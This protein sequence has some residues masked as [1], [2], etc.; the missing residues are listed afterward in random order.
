MVSLNINLDDLDSISA[1]DSSYCHQSINNLTDQLEFSWSD[2]QRLD[3]SKISTDISAVYFCGMGG[4]AY[5][6]RITKFLFR[7]RLKIPFEIVDNYN[8]P[9]SVDNRSLIFCA[10]YSGHTEETLSCLNQAI[11]RNL[12]LIGVTTGG[13]LAKILKQSN[14]P[15]YQ[16]STKLNPSNQPRL[17]QGYMIASSL[18]LLNK[19]KFIDIESSELIEI[20]SELKKRNLTLRWDSLSNA[21]LAKSVALKFKSKS[22]FFIAGDFLEGTVHA[23]RNPINETG[24]HFASYFI[25]PE[26]NH[27]LLEGL[28]FPPQLKSSV[29]F[30]LINSKNYSQKMQQRIQLTNEVIQ[31]N[32]IETIEIKLT[33]NSNLGQTFEFIQLL[34]YISFYLSVVHGINPAPVPWVDYFKNKLK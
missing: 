28:S 22:I 2:A 30:V 24:K 17:G 6:G 15:V 18:S 20:F 3:L 34:S 16:F 14:L 13:N 5:A 4:S 29:L 33:F 23:V 21:N 11:S 32:G 9:A 25:I 27:H 7:D 1:F 10:S 19:L 8:L 31:K 12:N 26:L